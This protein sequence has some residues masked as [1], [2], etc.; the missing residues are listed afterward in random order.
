MF[1]TRS[2]KEREIHVNRILG[3]VMGSLDDPQ[4]GKDKI[5]M[6]CMF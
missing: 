4:S 3:Q 2:R 6:L 5:K 1:K